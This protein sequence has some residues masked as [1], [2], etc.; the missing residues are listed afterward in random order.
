[1]ET[2]AKKFMA[3][4]TLEGLSTRQDGSASIRFSTQELAPE[5]LVAFMQFRGKFGYLLFK[6]TEFKVSDV[7]KNDP[8]FDGKTPS[9]RLR[10]VLYVQWKQKGASGDFENFYRQQIEKVIEH[11]KS[12]LT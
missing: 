7:P 9:Q 3:P 4:A 8:E 11:I 2:E 6:E 5:D 1:M 12:L 10:N